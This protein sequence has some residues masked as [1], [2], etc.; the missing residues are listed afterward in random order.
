[1]ELSLLLSMVNLHHFYQVLINTW[2]KLKNMQ[3][4]IFKEIWSDNML[5]ISK[6]E[7]CK[8]ISNLK[9]NGL[10]TLDQ[11]LKLTSALLKVIWTH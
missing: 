2:V 9:N 7:T 6:L 5:I 11:L 8:N 4:M 1:M 3:Q 10:K